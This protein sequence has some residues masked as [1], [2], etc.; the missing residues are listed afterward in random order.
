MSGGIWLTKPKIIQGVDVD[1]ADRQHPEDRRRG[2]GPDGAKRGSQL[3][4]R[5]RPC[6]HDVT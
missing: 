6:A 3:T 1:L 4:T 5:A 2:E